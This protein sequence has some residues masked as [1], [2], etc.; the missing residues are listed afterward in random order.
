MAI[1][2]VIVKSL[3]WLKAAAVSQ[4]T[5]IARNSDAS[6]EMQRAELS[7]LLNSEHKAHQGDW[8]NKPQAAQAQEEVVCACN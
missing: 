3:F 1:Q 5:Y 2:L 7:R 4:E 6:P 8:R